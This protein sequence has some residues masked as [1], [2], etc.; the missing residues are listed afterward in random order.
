MVLAQEEFAAD[1]DRGCP[2]V[3]GG[4]LSHVMAAKA[5]AFAARAHEGQTRKGDGAESPYLCHLLIVAG[6]IREH[7]GADGSTGAARIE[8]VPGPFA[9]PGQLPAEAGPGSRAGQAGGAHC[10]RWMGLCVGV[11]G[12]CFFYGLLLS[13]LIV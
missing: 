1:V 4:P 3:L 2:M 9:A 13:C 12:C 5:V 7:G 10:Q 8:S 6:S 11:C